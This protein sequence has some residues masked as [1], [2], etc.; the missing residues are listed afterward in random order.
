MMA[1][2]L[3]WVANLGEVFCAMCPH[4]ARNRELGGDLMVYPDVSRS[5]STGQGQGP[6]CAH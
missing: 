5:R 2:A 3:T 4:M 1:I 6:T